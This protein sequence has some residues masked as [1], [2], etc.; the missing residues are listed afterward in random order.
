MANQA[1]IRLGRRTMIRYAV[2]ILL[3]LTM[4]ASAEDMN[5]ANS[6]LPGCKG[7]LGTQMWEQGRCA[8]FIE[9]LRYGV[10]GR[11]FCPPNG[12]TTVQSGAHG[13]RAPKGEQN[14]NYR[15][16]YYTAEQS[17]NVGR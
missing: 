16:G 13:S 1:Q 10:G 3:A 11:D 17:P 6:I 9:G 5:D 15:H 7:T 14:G 8:G 2:A 4:P 12:V